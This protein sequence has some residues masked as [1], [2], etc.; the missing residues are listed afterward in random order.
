MLNINRKTAV[1]ALAAALSLPAWAQSTTGSGSTGST[2]SPTATTGTTTSTRR[3]E[4][5]EDHGKWGWLG[6]LGL[7]GLLGLRKPEHRV[8]TTRTSPQ[9]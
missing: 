8:D 3:D 5:R 7:A 4:D 9:R 2:A 6:L 1:I